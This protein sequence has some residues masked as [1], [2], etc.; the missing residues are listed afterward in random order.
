MKK[1]GVDLNSGG[2]K[3]FFLLHIEKLILGG[4]VLLLLFLFWNGWSTEKYTKSEPAKLSKLAT[5]AAGKITET[6]NWNEIAEFRRGDD[7]A[8]DRIKMASETKLDPNAYA[9]RRLL[10]TPKA[11]LGLRTDPILVNPTN[12][13]AKAIT[14]PV[15]IKTIYSPNYTSAI[16][17]LPAAGAVDAGDGR[18]GGGRGGGGRGGGG[19]DRGGGGAERS[20]GGD[21]RGGDTGRGGGGRNGSRDADDEEGD[22]VGSAMS[23]VMLKELVGFRPAGHQAGVTGH[24]FVLDGVAVT[25][26]VNFG[27]QFKSYEKA[28]RNALGYYPYRDRPVY[29]YLEVQRREF[30]A[31]PDNQNEWEDISER[32]Y[33]DIYAVERAPEIVS[34][35]NYDSVLTRNIPPIVNMD[36][37]DFSIHPQVKARKLIPDMM[38]K[39]TTMGTEDR[40]STTNT[41]IGMEDEESDDLDSDEA[42]NSDEQETGVEAMRGNNWDLYEKLNRLARPKSD[43]KLIRF[44]DFRTRQG[45]TYEYRVRL[46]LNDPNDVNA[47]RNAGGDEE[48]G[49]LALGAEGALGDGGGGDGR[50]GGGRGG[51]G[52][53]G[54]GRGGDAGRDSGGGGGGGGGRGGEGGRNSGDGD[55]DADLRNAEFVALDINQ[56]EPDVRARV[57]A[58]NNDLPPFNFGPL[59]AKDADNEQEIDNETRR[60][61]AYKKR[62]TKVLEN[63]WATEWSQP[64]APVTAGGSP[65]EFYA[66]KTIPGSLLKF[67]NGS[68]PRSEPTA[69]IVTSFWSSNAYKAED[70]DAYQ[71][72][73]PSVRTVIR[74]DVLN[75]KVKKAHVLDPLTTEVKRVE[76]TTILA[77]AV[78]VD[79]MGGE[80]A[81]GKFVVPVNLDSEMLVMDANGSFHLQNSRIDHRDYRNSLFLP[82]ESNEY[83]K[84]K[85]KSTDSDSRGGGRNGGGRGGGNEDGAVDSLPGFGGGG[86]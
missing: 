42:E 85:K 63:A 21:D 44:F 36:Y 3:T 58:K 62:M 74:G 6:D 48:A 59:P 82:D 2:M 28:F 22:F 23:N 52:R 7:T 38:D 39:R 14:G 25:G 50:G 32:F 18:G 33:D 9:V 55:D 65:A 29:L 10:G 1:S 15:L 31:D 13:V 11:T 16:S 73:I 41:M 84:K 75:Y 43:L 46:W 8:D 80:P 69:K 51:G 19:A 71:T 4:S 66:G 26:V 67:D 40:S 70:D 57:R 27:E 61:K 56:Q 35:A 5:D 20:G 49:A 37:R 17:G 45:V 86:R 76:D 64:T 79:M 24:P 72:A 68:I 53:G 78:V 77:N 60:R 81:P 30:S 83:G 34:P 54:G 47:F 12:L